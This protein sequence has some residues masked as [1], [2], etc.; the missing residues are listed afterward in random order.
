MFGRRFTRL[1]RRALNKNKKGGWRKPKA[2]YVA[3]DW[4]QES[5]KQREKQEARAGPQ[6]FAKHY[7]KDASNQCHL[8]TQM[9]LHQCTEYAK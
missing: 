4:G 2:N 1:I 8:K 7:N 9:F 3:K 5:R 6:S